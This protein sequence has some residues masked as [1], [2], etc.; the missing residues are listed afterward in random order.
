MQI[1]EIEPATFQLQGAGSTHGGLWGHAPLTFSNPIFAS[2]PPLGYG[3]VRR[4]EEHNNIDT[5][6]FYQ[7]RISPCVSGNVLSH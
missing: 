3:W 2:P 7:G 4:E 1:R 6:T 5:I